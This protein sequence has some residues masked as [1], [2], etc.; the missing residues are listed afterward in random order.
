[1]LEMI[2]GKK[3][4]LSKGKPNYLPVAEQNKKSPQKY[5][6]NL[7]SAMMIGDYYMPRQSTS[8]NSQN[9]VTNPS[10]EDYD[11]KC[12][13]AAHEALKLANS[14]KV[15]EEKYLQYDHFTHKRRFDYTSDI[16]EDRLHKDS[17]TY[18]K[19]GF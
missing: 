7:I 3:G 17:N 8:I 19:Q 1:M 5:D 15:K 18:K 9:Y 10:Q 11:F 13:M 4:S 2:N 6:Q 16:Q 12:L 14:N